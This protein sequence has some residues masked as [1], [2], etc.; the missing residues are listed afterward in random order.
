MMDR[1]VYKLQKSLGRYRVLL[2]VS[3][4]PNPPNFGRMSRC[5][6]NDLHKTTNKRVQKMAKNTLRV[7]LV[8][9][10]VAVLMHTCKRELSPT[11]LVC[12]R[13]HNV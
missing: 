2:E 9:S 4:A 3:N 5:L 10:S 8:I 7:S 6:F 13:R 1:W 12:P 11:H